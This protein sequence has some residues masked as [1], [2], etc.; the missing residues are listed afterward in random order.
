MIGILERLHDAFEQDNNHFMAAFI[1]AIQH[2]DES[3]ELE[4]FK[5]ECDNSFDE[6]SIYAHELADDVISLLDRV[7]QLE[8]ALNWM[9]IQTR[10]PRAYIPSIYTLNHICREALEGK[11]GKY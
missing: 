8:S 1:Y 2:K 9:E 3:A 5:Q 4:Q 11:W 7:R 10:N 6:F